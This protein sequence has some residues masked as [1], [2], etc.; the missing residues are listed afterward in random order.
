MAFKPYNNHRNERDIYAKYDKPKNARYVDNGDVKVFGFRSGKIYKMLPAA[1]YYAIAAYYLIGGI[2]GEFANFQFEPID[3]ILNVLKYIFYIIMY[4]SPLI[5]LSDF[6]YTKSLPL[7]KN[8]TI[9]SSL[10]GLIIVIVFCLFM[11][12][13]NKMCLSETYYKSAEAYYETVEATSE[14]KSET[15]VQNET[16]TIEET[17][18]VE[19]TA[20]EK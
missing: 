16:S 18:V 20:K 15:S 10:I 14:S 17:T 13:V 12:M 8:K 19:T 3:Y 9:G 7:F 2:Y 11:T 4:F 1:I 5:F 6:K